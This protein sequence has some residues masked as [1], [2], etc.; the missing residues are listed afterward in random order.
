MTLVAIE[1]GPASSMFGDNTKTCE[2]DN[3]IHLCLEQSVIPTISQRW[4]E[5]PSR[6]NEMSLQRSNTSTPQ[7]HT[8]RRNTCQVLRVLLEGGSDIN[9]VDGAGHTLAM[10][11]ASTGECSLLKFLVSEGGADLWVRN[12]D[13]RTAAFLAATNGHVR[14]LAFVLGDVDYSSSSG[15]KI[16]ETKGEGETELSSCERRNTTFPAAASA[17]ADA[18]DNTG[19]TPLWAAAAHGH[20]DTVKYL[21]ERWS[22]S[23]NARDAT[24][25]T[26]SWMAVSVVGDLFVSAFASV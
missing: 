5:R 15:G 3:Y 14:C 17:R 13:G 6:P 19:C 23:P 16:A 11:A 7:S 10:A 26:A 20:V 18:E 24:G 2:T 4:H 22:A 9:Q 21:L 12:S 25:A 8:T 1:A